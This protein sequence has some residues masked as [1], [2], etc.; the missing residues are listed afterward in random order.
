MMGLWA[1]NATAE[2]KWRTVLEG[3]LTVKTREVAGSDVHEYEVTGAM[4]AAV[5]DVQS[6]LSDPERFVKF[7]PHVKE[8]RI[9]KREGQNDRVY[10]KV[11][12][13]VGDPRDYVTEVTLLES[14][15]PDGSGTFRQKWRAVNDALPERDGVTRI[16]VN[17]GSW[18]ITPSNGGRQSTIIYRFRVDPG[19]W[20]PGFVADMANK[21]AIPATIRAIEQ[22]AK[23]RS[24]TRGVGGSGSSGT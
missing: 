11:Q 22:E 13:P 12:P 9:L 4:D 1:T 24:A 16:T 6:T 17:E 19:G 3:P 21:K 10:T 2:E 18:E 8:S 14:V 7:M 15:K 20:V 23:R 5:A